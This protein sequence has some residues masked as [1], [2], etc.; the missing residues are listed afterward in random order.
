MRHALGLMNKP[1]STENRLAFFCTPKEFDFYQSQAEL[2]DK[3]KLILDD[4]HFGHKKMYARL[5]ADCEKLVSD[6]KRLLAKLKQ[7]ICVDRYLLLCHKMF[8]NREFGKTD[9]RTSYK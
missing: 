4:P 9:V 1:C 8:Y 3:T 5:S 7:N 2:E 6:E